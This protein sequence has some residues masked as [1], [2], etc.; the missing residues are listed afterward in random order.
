MHAIFTGSSELKY[1]TTV[2]IGNMSQA[3][4]GICRQALFSKDVCTDAL[5]CGH[6]I[7]RSCLLRIQ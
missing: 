7:H 6:V 1:Y 3:V 4:C 5:R 2:K